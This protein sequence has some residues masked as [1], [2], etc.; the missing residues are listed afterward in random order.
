MSYPRALIFSLL[1]L[2]APVVRA[3]VILQYFGTSWNEIER[4]VPELVERGYDSLWLPPPFKAGAGTYSVGFDTLDRFDLGDRDQS[5]TVRTK[6]GTKDDLLRLMRTA[7]RFGMRVY[8]D[9]VMAHNAGALDKTVDPGELFPGAPGFV[10]EDFHLV[11]ESN[12][13][14]RKAADWPDWNDEW[15]VL[16][17]NPFAWD[18][19]QESPQNV[20]FNPTGTAEGHT[21]PKWSGIRHPG[22]TERY[23]DTDLTVATNGTGGAVHPFANKEPFQ[24]VG[25]SDGGIVGANNGRFD[26]KDLNG[27]GQHEGGEPSE[28]FTDTGVDPTVSARRTTAWGYGDGIYNMGNPVA[29]DVNGML[30]R[31]VRW[32]VDEAKPDGF[33]LDAVKHVPSYFFGKQD[34]ADKDRSNWGYGGQIQEQFNL[35]RGYGDWGNHRDTLFNGENEVRDDAMLFG[36]HLGSPPAEGGYLSAGMR[37]ANDNTLNTVRSSIGSNLSGFDAPNYGGYG[38]SGQTVNYVM[39]HDNAWLYG[40]DRA[41]AHAYILTREG[42]PIVYTDGYNEAGAPDYFPKP[43]DVPFLGQFGDNSVI[44]AVAVHRDF[45]RGSQ[46]GRWS[47]QNYVAYERVDMRERK[48][49]GSWNGPTLLFMMARGYQLNGQGRLFSTGFPVG[50]TLVNHS[51]YGGRFRVAVNGSSQLVDGSGNAPLV[52]PGEWFAFSW[53]NPRMPRVWQ[54]ARADEEIRPI[55]I[56][57]NGVQVPEMDHWR[58]DGKDGDND[59]NPYG[60]AVA[61]RAAKSYRVKIPRVTDGANLS[62]VARADGSAQ[63]MRLKL[64]GGIDV[65]SQLALGPLTGELRDFP[66]GATADQVNASDVGDRRLENSSDTYLGYEQMKFVRRGAE[67]FAAQN[68]VRNVIGSPGAETYQA[69]IG[70]AGFTVNNGNGV[71]SNRGTATWAYHD[72]AAGNQLTPLVPQFSPAPESAAGQPVGIFVKVGYSNQID[73]VRIYYTTD[74]VT[75]PEGSGG[76]GKGTTQV[77]EAVFHANGSNDGTGL[78]DWWRAV[79]PALPNGTVLRYKVGVTKLSAGSVF[80]F[81]GD[82]IDLAE[83]METVFEIT[84]FNAATV[85]YHIHN[86]NGTMGAGLDEGFHVLRSRAFVNR[87]DGASI[88]RTETQVFYYDAHRSEGEIVY[89]KSGDG[90]GGSS[91]GVVVATD[92]GVTEVWYYLDDLDP[93][94]DDPAK[95]NGLNA[96]K[97]ANAVATPTN[98][99]STDYKKEWRFSYE[100]IPSSGLARIVVR[101]KEASS[102]DDMNLTDVAGHYT[103]LERQVN[104]G[105]SINFN[106]GYPSLAGETVD[107]NYVMKVFFRKELIPS[108]MSD[109]DFLNEFSILISST[110][111]GDPDGAVLQPRSGYRLVKDA[112]ATEDMV[113]F[114]FPNLY[115]GIPNFLHTV[116]A[117]H[118]RGSL[119]LGDSELVK[120][121]AS[122]TGDSDG[123]GL[124]DWWELLQGWNPNSGFGINGASGD[125]DGDG[126]SNLDEYLFGMNSRVADSEAKPTLTIERSSDPALRWRLQFPTIPG[127]IYRWQRSG[128]L[129]GW[130]NLGASVDTA[131][132]T[133]PGMIELLDDGAGSAGFYRIQVTDEP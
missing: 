59:F 16:N 48:D 23:L 85:P 43:S 51:P 40:G 69:V 44:S 15:Q 97:R 11:R 119:T 47:D 33:R 61:D 4:R 13:T 95:G 106:I 101:L 130:G 46:I 1:A 6:Y 53:H 45:A 41:S 111:S 115:N 42:L 104:T 90:V 73:K 72:P 108:G 81:N 93:G 102:S 70:T 67:K 14:W 79:L 87:T 25:Y 34:G 122:G 83:R 121:R 103:T 49:G 132:H 91:Y 114:T 8:F 55:T 29:E 30:N 7:H 9:N 109:A 112:T 57:Q 27:N 68:T 64:D 110:A 5:G 89:P 86:D 56:L 105:S 75:F 35:S 92:P 80:P 94:N 88:F 2:A 123:D 21:Y 60:V 77:V 76:V 131:A 39:S 32:F 113:E 52:S 19:A 100:D 17:R 124:P 116:R 18:I 24:D 22:M 82:D 84:G 98:L 31:A 125:D 127:R 58:T 128:T 36:E 28:P 118:H 63:N 3:E 96:W 12:G 66:P 37:I 50:A 54:A 71:N 78:P 120:M 99:G 133:A 107:Q 74:G 65:N 26:F 38:S 10:P 62:F 129:G 20:S 126:V 117:E